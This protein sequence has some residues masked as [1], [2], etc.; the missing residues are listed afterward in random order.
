MDSAETSQ[1]HGIFLRYREKTKTAI[2]VISRTTTPLNL[3]K[4]GGSDMP[5][6][7]EVGNTLPPLQ[8]C[9]HLKGSGCVT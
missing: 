5:M 4:V 2:Q 1:L 8:P 6:K 7:W 3:S 9:S